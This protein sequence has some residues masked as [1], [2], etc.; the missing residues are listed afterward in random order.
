MTEYLYAGIIVVVEKDSGRPDRAIYCRVSECR[1]IH[2]W[3]Q[4][5]GATR[6]LCDYQPTKRL[7]KSFH[8]VYYNGIL[9]SIRIIQKLAEWQISRYLLSFTTC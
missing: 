2:Y 1:S 5:A 9:L 6:S 7:D 4:Y 3:K 8:D